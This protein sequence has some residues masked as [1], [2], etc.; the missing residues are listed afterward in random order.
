M[1]IIV[2]LRHHCNQHVDIKRQALYNILFFY[3]I[4][5]LFIFPST[6]NDTISVLE[7]LFYNK[8]NEYV[9]HGDEYSI[10]RS[11]FCEFILLIW[12][13]KLCIIPP[14]TAN[15][16]RIRNAVKMQKYW[17]DKFIWNENSAKDDYSHF[18]S[19]K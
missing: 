12:K 9:Y 3:S 19:L 14:S 10:K 2:S 1:F 15:T 13:M 11:F 4:L 6:V 8:R 16:K 18:Q 17:R 7:Y 5:Y